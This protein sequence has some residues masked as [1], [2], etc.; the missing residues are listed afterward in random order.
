MYIL[1]TSDIC[2]LF[3]MDAE[4]IELEN[5]T[6]VEEFYA[7]VEYK[8]LSLSKGVTMPLEDKSKTKNRSKDWLGFLKALWN[9]SGLFNLQSPTL[10]LVTDYP[11]DTLVT[12]F[13]RYI[14]EK[15]FKSVEFIMFEGEKYPVITLARKF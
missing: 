3:L 4:A 9:C 2:E 11:Y 7:L 5:K 13:S 15:I 1:K 8:R 6:T 14:F 10:I 12:K